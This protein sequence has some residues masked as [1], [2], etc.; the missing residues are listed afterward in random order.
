[1]ANDPDVSEILSRWPSRRAIFDDVTHAGGTIKMYAIHRWFQ[2]GRVD[3]EHWEA[4]IAGAQRR[5]IECS[6]DD[7]SKAHRGYER[8]GHTTSDVHQSPRGQAARPEAAE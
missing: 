3:P 8:I 7:L 4:L 6:A 5:G 1:M 2:R